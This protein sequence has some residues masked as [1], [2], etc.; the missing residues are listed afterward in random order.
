MRELSSAE[1][2]GIAKKFTG[3]IEAFPLHTHSAIV[4]MVKVG[5]QHRQIGAQKEL[6]DKQQALAEEQ[7]RLQRQHM[8]LL[9]ATY[10]REQAESLKTAGLALVP[11]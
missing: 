5:I 6:A 2:Y 10:D 4:E 1:M 9:Q 8:D 11:N 3:E 7:L